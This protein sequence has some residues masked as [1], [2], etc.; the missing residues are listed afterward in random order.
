MNEVDGS[1]EVANL[2]EERKVGFGLDILKSAMKFKEYQ[3]YL[4]SFDLKIHIS[5]VN[6]DE[7]VITTPFRVLPV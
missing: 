4:I 6:G 5:Y 3:N 1:N 2:L 7:P